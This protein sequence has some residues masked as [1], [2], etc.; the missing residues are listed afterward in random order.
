VAA[1][2]LSWEFD[3]RGNPPAWSAYPFVI[4]EPAMRFDKR[5]KLKGYFVLIGFDSRKAPEVPV[6]DPRT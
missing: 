6:V 1:S 3:T 2:P 4:Q 5:L